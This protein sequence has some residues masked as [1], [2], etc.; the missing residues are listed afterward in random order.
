MVIIYTCNLLAG[1]SITIIFLSLQIHA[2]YVA[3]VIVATAMT[4]FRFH[5][6]GWGNQPPVGAQT[7]FGTGKCPPPLIDKVL[8]L[9]KIQLASDN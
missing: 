9:N 3:A 5:A 8:N 6:L 2:K 1:S 4:A 7:C